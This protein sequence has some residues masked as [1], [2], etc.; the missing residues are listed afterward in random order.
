MKEQD[1]LKL[2][3]LNKRVEDAIK[4]RRKWL[5]SKMPE[6]AKVQVGEA[7]YDLNKGIK[8]GVVSKHYRYWQDR[9]EGV[10]DTSL[11]INYEYNT[12][13]NCYD[14]T[15]RQYVCVGT[16]EDLIKHKKEE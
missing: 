5:D 14:N 2:D 1:R 13:G 7:I 8:L 6:Y 11:D 12:G 16:I 10:R 4:E 15:S 3:E 9:D